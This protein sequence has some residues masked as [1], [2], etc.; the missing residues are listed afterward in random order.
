MRRT[1]TLHVHLA[2]PLKS[3]PNP[4]EEQPKCGHLWDGSHQDGHTVGGLVG[5][6]RDPA[7]REP[8][9]IVVLDM[10]PAVVNAVRPR[11]FDSNRNRH[12]G[13]T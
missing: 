9:G 12:R 13:Q 10:E 3:H 1:L 7:S 2:P 4:C 5:I 11:G 8:L 6:A